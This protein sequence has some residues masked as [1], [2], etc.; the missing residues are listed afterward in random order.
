MG[1]LGNVLSALALLLSGGGIA[2]LIDAFARRRQARATVAETLTDSTLEWAQALRADAVELR[3]EAGDARRETARFRREINEARRE[4]DELSVKVRHLVALI[5]D[6]YMTLDR[7]RV[8]IPPE[9]G[10]FGAVGKV[11]DKI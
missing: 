5:H 11:P 2:A 3:R 4:L 6:P 9:N 1:T 10:T 8:I 7:L